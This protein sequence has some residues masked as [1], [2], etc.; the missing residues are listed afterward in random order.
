M[1][2]SV[3]IPAVAVSS[4]IP[5]PAVTPP[6]RTTVA[7]SSSGE[8]VRALGEA[9]D[10]GFTAYTL[11]PGRFLDALEAAADRGAR[12]HVVLEAHPFDNGTGEL[13]K[14]NEATV[15]ELRTHGV[16]AV[17]HDAGKA[18]LHMKAA[19][20]DGVA[21]LDDRN[22]PDDGHDTIV[23]TT[24]RDDVAAVRSAI[25]GKPGSDAH[26]WTQKD[27]ATRAEAATIR[28]APG[29]DVA[30]ETESFGF[31]PVYGALRARAK[32][33]DHV[34]VLVQSMDLA[35]S[36]RASAALHK[37]AEAGAEVRVGNSDEKI[38]VAGD[39]AWV[40]SANASAGR[41]Q[42]IDWGMRTKIPA[43]IDALR[44]RYE[45]NWNEGRAFG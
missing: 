13:T 1:L 29:H 30:F 39:R 41:P 23:R 21:F 11:R 20:V 28:W 31:G 16:D 33:G 19:L 35:G 3:Q 12:V 17:L 42:T 7:L 5:R 44:T 14:A 18:S 9:K 32:A 43:L 8:I 34:R 25:A 37:L 27:D 15:A 26:L 24:D 2:Q 6:S 40:G 10:I 4:P 45:A 36:P 22:W 38:V